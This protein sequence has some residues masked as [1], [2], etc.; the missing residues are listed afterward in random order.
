M[1]VVSYKRKISQSCQKQNDKKNQKTN[2]HNHHS[3]SLSKKTK[4]LQKYWKTA[5]VKSWL[6]YSIF[7]KSWD[8]L[9]RCNSLQTCNVM[10]ENPCWRGAFALC[11]QDRPIL[12]LC[13][14]LADTTPALP[15]C[16]EKQTGA[17]SQRLNNQQVNA[18]YHPEKLGKKVKLAGFRKK[19]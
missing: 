10:G 12:R 19:K 17:L 7:Q 3:S 2:Y 18:T 8:F 16:A 11:R 5:S 15:Q 6:C 14:C 4:S 13:P 1:H 9:Q